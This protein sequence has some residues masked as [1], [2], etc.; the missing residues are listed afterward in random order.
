MEGKVRNEVDAAIVDGLKEAIFDR[1]STLCGQGEAFPA[2][3]AGSNNK[4]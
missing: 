4:V 2:R 3:G 1:L